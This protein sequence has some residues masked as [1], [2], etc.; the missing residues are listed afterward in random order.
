MH[1][2]GDDPTPALAPA[3]RHDRAPV[4]LKSHHGAVLHQVM[5]VAIGVGLVI[6]LGVGDAVA[7]SIHTDTP[8]LLMVC[9]IAPM[10]LASALFWLVGQLL[11]LTQR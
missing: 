2:Y 1:S 11:R 7:R 9:L 8:W 10:A 4:W 3:A 6:S 5:I